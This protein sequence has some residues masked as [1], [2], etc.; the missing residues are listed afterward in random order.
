MH[1]TCHLRT[2]LTKF[3]CYNILQIVPCDVS[4]TMEGCTDSITAEIYP[5]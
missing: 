2:F 5:A 3:W 4:V 1:V